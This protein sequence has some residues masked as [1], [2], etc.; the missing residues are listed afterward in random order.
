[1]LKFIAVVYKLPSLSEPDFHR[2]FI[3][4]HG[5]LALRIPGLLRYVQNFVVADST[6][7]HPG[8]N[9]VIEFYFDDWDSLQAAWQSPEGLAATG[10]LKHCA[11]LSRT[12]WSVV[13]E[14]VFAGT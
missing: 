9:A 8:W 10:D 5:R 3:E 13:E 14:R 7:E 2:Y 1:M 11:D 12:T 6:R 4:V